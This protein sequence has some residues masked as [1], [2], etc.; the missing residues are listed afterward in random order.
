MR[1]LTF[2]FEDF[3]MNRDNAYRANNFTYV[4]Q[5]GEKVDIISGRKLTYK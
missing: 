5:K 3:S 1:T 4:P 2:G